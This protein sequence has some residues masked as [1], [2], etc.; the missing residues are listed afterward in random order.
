MQARPGVYRGHSVDAAEGCRTEKPCLQPIWRV[1]A[2]GFCSGEACNTYI[3]TYARAH[4]QSYT[5]SNKVYDCTRQNKW[6]IQVVAIGNAFTL[7][8]CDHWS[9]MRT[10]RSTFCLLGVWTRVS[11]N[12]GNNCFMLIQ[13]KSRGVAKGPRGPRSPKDVRKNFQQLQNRSRKSK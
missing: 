1:D 13:F 9:W 10:C 12:E 4:T 8:R 7:Q 6:T 11:M 3:Y 5:V 2:G